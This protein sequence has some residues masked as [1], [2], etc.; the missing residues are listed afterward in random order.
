MTK[1]MAAGLL[2]L[3]VAVV[4]CGCSVAQIDTWTSRTPTASQTPAAGILRQPSWRGL[5]NDKSPGDL[6]A[7]RLTKQADEQHQ[8]LLE[9]DPRGT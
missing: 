6:R 1:V 2:A 7:K 3:A 8:W 4:G 9:G 5:R